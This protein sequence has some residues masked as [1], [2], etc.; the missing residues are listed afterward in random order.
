LATGENGAE[1]ARSRGV[2]GPGWK[3]S[4]AWSVALTRT[5]GRVLRGGGGGAAW[6]GMEGTRSARKKVKVRS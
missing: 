1:A 6:R 2:L 4:Q 5:T 3:K